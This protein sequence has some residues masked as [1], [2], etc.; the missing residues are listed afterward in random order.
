MQHLDYRQVREAL[1]H[2]DEDPANPDNV[3]LFYSGWSVPKSRFGGHPL[4]HRTTNPYGLTSPHSELLAGTCLA[5]P[6]MNILLI[7]HG[8]VAR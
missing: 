7:Y 1:K 6:A 8:N 5:K 4:Q 2:T 3:I